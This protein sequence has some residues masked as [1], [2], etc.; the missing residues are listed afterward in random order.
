[1]VEAVGNRN[2]SA[3]NHKILALAVRRLG[4]LGSH[5]DMAL[6]ITVTVHSDHRRNPLVFLHKDLAFGAFTDSGLKLNKGVLC[7]CVAL[8]MRASAARYQ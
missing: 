6:Q 8:R 5:D 3:R 4:S 1:M 2:A 7:Q